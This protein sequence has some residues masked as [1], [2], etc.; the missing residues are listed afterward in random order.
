M[1]IDQ[2][3]EQIESYYGEYQE[4]NYRVKVL[5]KGYLKDF[6]QA[7]LPELLKLVMM[8]HAVNYG[9]PDI[10]AVEKAYDYA[11]KNNKCQDLKYLAPANYYIEDTP[12]EEELAKTRE[13]I[14]SG[15]GKSLT[16]LFNQKMHD[17]EKDLKDK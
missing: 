7:K 13:L 8:N 6:K 10:S 5:L 3:V 17:M 12:T 2:F 16:E 14:A 15:E 4:K 9:T 11:L 1:T